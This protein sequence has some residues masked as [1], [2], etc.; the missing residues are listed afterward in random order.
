MVTIEKRSNQDGTVTY[1]VKLRRTGHP[2]RIATFRRYA[3]ARV[4]AQR[5]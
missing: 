1:G 4:W 2:T 5:D 3:D